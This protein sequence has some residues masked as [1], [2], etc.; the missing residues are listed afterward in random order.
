MTFHSFLSIAIIGLGAAVAFRILTIP[1][2][3]NEAEIAATCC[4][5]LIGVASYLLRHG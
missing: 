4:I 1:I 2:S 3:G 5:G